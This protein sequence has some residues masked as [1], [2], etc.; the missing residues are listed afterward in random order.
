MAKTKLK[1]PTKKTTKYY[2]YHEVTKYLE[3]LHGK[4]FRDY[5]GKFTKDGNDDAPYQDFWHWICDHNEVSNGCYIFLP[6]WDYHMNSKDT[7][8]WKKEIMQYYYDFLGQD[9][10][11][12][13]WVDW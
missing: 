1:K 6:D 2:D 11:E 7:E 8:P 10:F 9:Y 12:R 3:K 13:M 4:D 5:A